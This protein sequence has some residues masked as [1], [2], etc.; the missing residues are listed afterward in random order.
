MQREKRN[1]LELYNDILF[2]IQEEG[3]KGDVKP[4]RVQHLCNTSYD[5]MSKYLDELYIKKMIEKSPLSLTDKGKK[6]L[7]DYSKIKDFIKEM[8]LEYVAKQ[9]LKNEI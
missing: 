4:T 1:K 7:Q 8:E 6:F 5:K 9:E 3:T 2:A